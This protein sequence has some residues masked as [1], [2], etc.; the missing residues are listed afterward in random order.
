[1]STELSPPWWRPDDYNPTL[2]NLVERQEVGLASLIGLAG[3]PSL[4][5]RT[6]P[7]QRSRKR[8]LT[9]GILTGGILGF[10]LAIH[11]A[12]SPNGNAVIHLGWYGT[13]V[14]S[15][16]SAKLLLSL[17]AGPITVTGIAEERLRRYKVAAVVT[18]MNEDPA[19]FAR[20]LSSILDSSRLPAAVTVIDDGSTST[21]CSNIARTL[22]PAFLAAGVDYQLIVFPENRGKRA[23][24]AAGFR[25]TWDADIYLCVDSD[26][27]LHPEALANGLRPFRDRRVQAT[28]GAVF[29]ANR[30]RNILTRLIDMRYCYAFLGERA[31][32][33]VL[34][35]V[36]CVCGSL[37]LYRGPTVRKYLDDFLSQ[38]F[39]GRPCTYGDDRRLTYY[40]LREGRVLLA[41]D[42]IA[43]TLVPSTMRHFLRQQLRWSKSF[44]R[45]SV[46]MVATVPPWRVCWW[47]TLIEIGTWSGFTS[48]L[49]Y[50][51]AVRPVLT[52]HFSILTYL[53]SVLILSYARSGHYIEAQHPDIGWV[54]RLGTLAIA[55][56]YGLIHMTLLL[57][58]RVIALLTLRDN[59][60]GTRKTVEVT[61]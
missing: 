10:V 5:L 23:G 16:I 15:V 6:Q 39:L 46:W 27:I 3:R 41:P 34:G 57:P 38:R 20:C 52:G 30:T 56:V 49:V 8:I 19:V 26:T 11:M 42:A 35:S 12:Q 47:L 58:L 18:C 9:V 28:T 31:A 1:L 36:L 51:V 14:L 32:Y 24:L 53:V 4:A 22:G 29:A 54:G 17:L 40:C 7:L 43:W 59:G 37:A 44:F 61:S 45:E 48:A 50:S 25:R 60:W 33:S 21:A 13:A 55:P 2:E